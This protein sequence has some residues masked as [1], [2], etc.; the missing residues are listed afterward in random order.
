MSQLPYHRVAIA[1][2]LNQFL[3]VHRTRDFG[4]WDSALLRKAV[5]HTCDVLAMK[6]KNAV[7]NLAAFCRSS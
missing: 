2:A 6:E 5:R 7:V 3:R 4:V 1:V